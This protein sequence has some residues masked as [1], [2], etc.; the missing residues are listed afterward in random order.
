MT[1]FEKVYKFHDAYKIA[2]NEG[3]DRD[4]I[5]L[6][7]KL[8]NEELNELRDELYVSSPDK[9]KVAKELAD[10]LYVIYGAGVAFGIDMDS[11]FEAVHQ[12]NMSKLDDKGQP[13]Y[14]EDGKVLKGPNYKAPDL[15]WVM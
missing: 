8:I 11:V 13:V 12:S 2:I 7:M 5:I 15:S 4:L 1:N 9:R 10:L 3:M 6:R 14:R